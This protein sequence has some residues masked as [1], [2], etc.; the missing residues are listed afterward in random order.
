MV[1]LELEAAAVLEFPAWWRASSAVR[2]A[3]GEQG[4]EAAEPEPEAA[5]A[6][7]RAKKKFTRFSAR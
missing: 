3:R 4:P 7:S 1:E 5:G 2:A 6:W